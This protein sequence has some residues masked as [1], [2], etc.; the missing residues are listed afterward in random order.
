VV[1]V[2]LLEMPSFVNNP[3]RSAH[4]V[5][6]S[7]LFA[8]LNANR[9]PAVSYI[10]PSGDSERAPGSVAEGESRVQGIIGAIMSSPEWA[11]SAVILTWS[12]WGG[13]YDHVAPPQVDGDGYGFRV[14]ALVISP[15]SRHGYV[16]HTTADFASILRFIEGLHSLTPLTQRDALASPMTSAFDF[17]ASPRPSTLG[18]SHA[19]T[20]GP[21]NLFRILV[22]WLLYSSSIAG[23]AWLMVGGVRRRRAPAGART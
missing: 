1:R 20:V 22:I 12:D 11:S 7:R 9:A 14:P 18:G 6:R 13:Y 21:Q 16:D 19:P 17:N 15:Y 2:P 23:A 3:A 5:E 4:I 8:D 10:F